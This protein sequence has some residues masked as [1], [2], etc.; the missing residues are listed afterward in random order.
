M[1]VFVYGTLKPRGHYHKSFCQ[2]KC[3]AAEA[4]KVKGTLYDLALD[5]PAMQEAIHP[6]SEGW[7]YGNLLC[8]ESSEVLAALDCL[9]GYDFTQS[10]EDNE[11]QRIRCDCFTLSGAFIARVWAYVMED[12]QL[13][14][15]AHRLIPCGNWPVGQI[16]PAR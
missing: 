1:Y 5:Y 15:Y 10:P 2:D 11:Y 14:R 16:R 8:F 13:S 12:E 9:E 3:L 7:V 6:E 4:A